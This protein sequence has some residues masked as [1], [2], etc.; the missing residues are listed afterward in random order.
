MLDFTMLAF[1]LSFRYRNPVVLLADGYL[2]QMTGRV[3][4]PANLGRPE[5]P[6]WAVF[7]DASHRANL[8][9]SIHL[10]EADL[11]AHNLRLS[12]KYAR[13]AASE[14]RA[15]AY[16]CHDAEV[17]LLAANTPARTA[18]GAVHE[19]R[20]RGIA[21]GLFRPQTLWPFPIA[22][23]RP[24]LRRARTIVVVEASE[25]QLEDEL[26]LALSHAGLGAGVE[27]DHVRRCGGALPGHHEVVAAVHQVVER[28]GVPA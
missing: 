16:R 22:A 25:G 20:E 5:V 27:I 7:G 4:L 19:L 11:E 18:K 6:A 14:A 21:A 28:R 17:L 24:L 3:V 15:E 12:A 2:G 8:V 13:I 23:L 26:R 9:S 1:E 10:S